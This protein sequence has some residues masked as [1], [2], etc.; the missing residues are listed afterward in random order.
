[1]NHPHLKNEVRIAITHCGVCGSDIQTIDDVYAVFK[2]PLMP[3][4]E[5]VWVSV[6]V[7]AGRHDPAA[8]ANGAKREKCSCAWRCKITAPGLLMA[9]FQRR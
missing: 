4:H 3:G 5:V 7:W 2:F 9:A 6:W 8:N 1:M